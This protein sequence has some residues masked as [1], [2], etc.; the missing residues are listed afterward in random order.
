[1]ADSPGPLEKSKAESGKR[2][3][4]VH[5]SERGLDR[6]AASD[7]KPRVYTGLVILNQHCRLW[8]RRL[9]MH[10]ADRHKGGIYNLV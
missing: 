9:R 2:K 10:L 4:H 5:F 8:G 1:M 7:S 3:S 6:I